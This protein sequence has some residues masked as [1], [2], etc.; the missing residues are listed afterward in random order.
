MSQSYTVLE[1]C[2]KAVKIST[3]QNVVR[4]FV[5]LFHVSFDGKIYYNEHWWPKNSDTQISI[6][7]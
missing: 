2:A 3:G 5:V 4:Q 1:E 6:F 7:K